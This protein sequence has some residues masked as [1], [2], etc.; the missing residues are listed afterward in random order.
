MPAPR[1][2]KS[3]EIAGYLGMTTR[4]GQNIMKIFEEN[5]K[6][7]SM[8]RRFTAAEK[9]KGTSLNR[10]GKPVK[11]VDYRIFAQWIAEQDGRSVDEV[12]QDVRQ[13]LTEARREAAENARA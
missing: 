9:A 8:G 7:V 12:A 13:W 11:L 6:T 2:M 3:C 4:T 5:G 10:P 1:M